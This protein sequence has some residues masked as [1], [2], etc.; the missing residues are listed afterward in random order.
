MAEFVLEFYASRAD[1][2]A[3]RRRTRRARLAA[4]AVTREGTP[5]R[6]VR[7]IYVPEDET[8][9]VLYEAASSDAV[10]R[11]AARAD[12]ASPRVAQTLAPDGERNNE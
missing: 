10:Q 6:Y 4:D 8:C 3:V 5:V 11:A 1:T 2:A 9:F 12:L 7:S